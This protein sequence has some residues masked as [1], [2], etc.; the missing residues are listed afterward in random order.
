MKQ[1][2]D[3]FAAAPEAMNTLLN[4]EQYLK[5]DMTQ[6]ERPLLE[7]VKI[8][9]SQINGCAYCVDMHSK[10]ARSIGE[11]SERLDCLIVWREVPCYSDR[12]SAALA[13]AEALTLLSQNDI[14]DQLYQSTRE[15][16]SEAQLVELSVNITAINAWNRIAV[17]FKPQ[18]G[19]Y[20]PGDHGG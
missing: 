16:F 7:L 6:L 14:S 20:Q 17:A 15:Y 2:L 1:R 8:R 9:V 13:W 19:T 3:Y 18:A 10:D 12:E 11:S 5:Q 4:S